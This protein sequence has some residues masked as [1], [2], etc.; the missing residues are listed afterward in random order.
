MEVPPPVLMYPPLPDP[1][2]DPDCGPEPSVFADPAHEI[3][4]A[5]QSDHVINPSDR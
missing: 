1:E 4:A 3:M 5:P 2:V